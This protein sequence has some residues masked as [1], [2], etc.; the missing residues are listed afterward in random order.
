MLQA[1]FRQ[2]MRT[3]HAP[4]SSLVPPAVEPTSEANPKLQEHAE[5]LD[6]VR[7]ICL[8][9]AAL[10]QLALYAVTIHIHTLNEGCSLYVAL[11]PSFFLHV[12]LLQVLFCFCSHKECAFKCIIV[13]L[14]L[15]LVMRIKAVKCCVA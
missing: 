10:S 5:A 15:A 4:P 12:R 1:G 13:L 8:A 7:K 2:Q 11:T 9:S 14:L 3:A 6:R